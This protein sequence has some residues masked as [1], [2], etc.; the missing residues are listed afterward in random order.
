MMSTAA[1]STPSLCRWLIA[2][3]ITMPFGM[4]SFSATS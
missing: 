3:P 4:R 2:T 1:V